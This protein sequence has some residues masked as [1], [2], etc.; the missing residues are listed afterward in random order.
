MEFKAVFINRHKELR[1]GWRM[2]IFILLLLTISF[3]LLASVERLDVDRQFFGSLILL[4][5]LLVTTFLVTKYINRKPLTAIGLS[6]HPSAFRELGAGC[7]LGFLMM[8]G[9]FVLEFV[10]GYIQVEHVQLTISGMAW[11]LLYALLFFGVAAMVEEILFRGYLFQTLL[12]GITFLPATVVMAVLFAVAHSMNPNV[13]FFALVNVGLA[14]VWL[15]FA[16]MKTRSLW[17]PFGL[18]VSWNFAQTTLYG[19]PTSG[20]SFADKKLALLT[21]SGPEW[22]TGGAFGPEGGVLATLALII[23]T[24]YLLKAQWITT[25]EGIITLDSVEDLIAPH[26]ILNEKS[27]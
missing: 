26:I 7:L 5:V 25:P 11:T 4:V 18:H 22:L 1:A 12:Q 10:M 3:P 9:I 20:G 17:L 23:C 8:T 6:F 19:F 2:V 21:Q 16:Y 13:G 27:Q 15:S 24:W 14:A